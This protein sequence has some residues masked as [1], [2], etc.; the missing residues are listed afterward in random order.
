MNAQDQVERLLAE[1]GSLLIRQNKHLVYRLPN[2]RNFVAAK[3]P[4]DPARAAQNNL[5]DLRRALGLPRRA[6]NTQEGA[7]MEPVQSRQSEPRP[8]QASAPQASSLTEPRPDNLQSRIAAFIAK[9]EAA[10]ELLMA[11]AQQLERRVQMLKALLPF[12]ED[13]ATEAALQTLIPAPVPPPVAAP[14]LLP[15][16]PQQ[17]TERVQVTRQLVFAAT[18]TFEGAFTIND[19]V[20]LMTA[21]R[22]INPDERRRI[23][24]SIA[25]CAVSLHERGELIKEEGHFG[26][27]QTVWKAARVSR[28]ATG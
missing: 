19:L 8:E 2:G 27:K 14:P 6:T 7:T 4:S 13:P 3:T 20:T 17:V 1:S 15:E 5:H 23:R 24:S 11:Q 18:Q 9:E 12:A 16:P 25:Q 22:Q 10:Q 26:R 21:G 28:G